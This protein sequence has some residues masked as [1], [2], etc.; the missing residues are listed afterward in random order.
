MGISGGNAGHDEKTSWQP[1]LMLIPGP[2]RSPKCVYARPRP[3][4]S[5]EDFVEG[6]Q[7]VILD[8]VDRCAQGDSDHGRGPGRTALA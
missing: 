1:V 2:D 5:D 6:F 4:A 7:P 8:T 3:R